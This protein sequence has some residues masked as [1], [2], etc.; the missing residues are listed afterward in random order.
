[1]SRGYNCTSVK[2]G[3]PS[4]FWG[5]FFTSTEKGIPSNIQGSLWNLLLFHNHN[6]TTPHNINMFAAPR[7]K[8][9][10]IKSTRLGRPKSATPGLQQRP[11]ALAAPAL[12]A[13]AAANPVIAEAS[14]VL[15]PAPVLEVI[16]IFGD[17]CSIC[18]DNDT[19]AVLTCGNGHSICTDCVENCVKAECSRIAILTKVAVLGLKCSCCDHTLAL[20][21][22]PRSF[23][24]PLMLAL[25]QNATSVAD[26]AATLRAER[27]QRAQREAE[28]TQAAILERHVTAVTAILRH[29]CPGCHQQW[30]GFTACC[31]LTCGWC[32]AIFCAHCN[33]QCDSNQACHE[34]IRECEDNPSFGHLSMSMAVYNNARNKRW[35]AEVRHYMDNNVPPAM[36]VPLME[37]FVHRFV[38]LGMDA[39]DF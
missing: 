11:R 29:T 32:S 19:S 35:M 6:H 9:V 14:P 13:D 8:R 28:D 23:L 24:Q 3:I 20:D 18:L 7:P 34:H 21:Q 17:P 16:E 26:R 22:I 37:K 33:L 15:A 30:E 5:L 12:T 36:S 4:L 1:M 10:V 38:E 31:A 39:N 27:E 2:K 25:Q